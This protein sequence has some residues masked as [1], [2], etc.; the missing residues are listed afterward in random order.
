MTVQNLAG[1][2]EPSNAGDRRSWLLRYSKGYDYLT[3]NASTGDFFLGGGALQGGLDDVGNPS[4]SEQ[5]IMALCHLSGAL[6]RLFEAAVDEQALSATMKSAW[7]GTLGFSSD[8]R[9]WVGRL[10][11]TLTGRQPQPMAGDSRAEWIAAGF[12]GSG[13]VYCWKSGRAIAVEILG[14]RDPDLPDALLPTEQ[15]YHTCDARDMAA[16]WLELS[17]R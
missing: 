3:Q 1:T 16:Y 4:D 13:M 9:P 6:P 10:P 17:V 15:R 11:A 2:N 14:K 5:S 7:T 8:G 12:C